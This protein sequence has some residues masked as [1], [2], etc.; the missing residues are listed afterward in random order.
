MK[1][2]NCIG[3]LGNQLFQY[4]MY[5]KL[6]IEYPTEIVLMDVHNFKGYNIHNGYELE[7]SLS[8]KIDYCTKWQK[9][10]LTSH[11]FHYSIRGLRKL[12]PKYE[13]VENKADEYSYIDF[14]EKYK[15][16]NTY[17]K[18]YWQNI[19]YVNDVI[20]EIRSDFISI[21]NL[22]KKNSKYK[23]ELQTSNSVSIHVRRGDYTN[24]PIFG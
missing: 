19:E 24:H 9:L 1:I 18:G 4:A 11:G 7:R 6:K 13:L 23:K 12:L 5:L 3:G 20:E 15:G 10:K 16:K 21:D 14:V 22:T 17:F 8:S 2:V